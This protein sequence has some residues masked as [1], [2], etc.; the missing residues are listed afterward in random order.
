MSIELIEVLA[1]LLELG[2]ELL[3]YFSHLTSANG[4]GVHVA[5]VVWYEPA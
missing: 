2:L 3:L 4:G 5:K 1:L